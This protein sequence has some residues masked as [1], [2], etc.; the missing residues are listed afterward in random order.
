MP[1]PD[2]DTPHL[3]PRIGIPV[4]V[5]AGTEEKVVAGLIEK[6]EP[7]ADGEKIERVVLDGADH[8]F[9]DLYSEEIADLLAER[10]GE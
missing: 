3:L 2:M 6:T 10:L 1:D 5:F 8:F 7:L 4:I 9:R